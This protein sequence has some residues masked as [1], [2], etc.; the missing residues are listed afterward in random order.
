M[1]LIKCANCTI[2]F[3]ETEKVVPSDEDAFKLSTPGGS[4][5]ML[6]ARRA[7][8]CTSESCDPVFTFELLLR[9]FI[10]FHLCK[11]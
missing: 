5:A 1:R 10:I 2:W 9:F 6:S 4:R 11:G 8:R 3:Q 7:A